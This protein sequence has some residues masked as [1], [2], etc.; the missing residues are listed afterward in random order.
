MDTIDSICYCIENNTPL[1]ICKYGDGE[2]FCAIKYDTGFKMERNCDNDT[3]TKK[4]SDSIKGGFTYITENHPNV[5][6]AKWFDKNTVEY[7]KLLSKKNINFIHYH[8]LLFELE[9]IKNDDKFAKKI[10]TYQ[11]IKKS[12]LKKIIVCNELM[13]KVKSLLNADVLVHIPMNSWFDTKFDEILEQVSKEISTDGNHIVITQCGLGAKVLI[14]ELYKKFPK[15]IYID[16]G[17]GLD[18]ICTKRDSRGWGYIYIEMENMFK[19][20][21]M[22]SPDWNDEKYDFIYDRAKK[23]LGLHVGPN[24]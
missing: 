18:C 2:Y 16:V 4:L 23:E 22:L 3:Y 15:G 19:K 12:N 5:M 21:D 20:Y 17:S 14:S 10:K 1:A 11:T 24:N 8:T 13:I 9:D 6:I 7:W